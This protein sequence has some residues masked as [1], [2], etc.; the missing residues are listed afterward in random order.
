MDAP[1]IICY[2]AI[3]ALKNVDE[4]FKAKH[5]NEINEF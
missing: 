2:C 4:I 1:K 3:R 5:L